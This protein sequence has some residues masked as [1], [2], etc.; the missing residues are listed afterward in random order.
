[1][2]CDTETRDF[3]ALVPASKQPIGEDIRTNARG[4]VKVIAVIATE[5]IGLLVAHGVRVKERM[6]WSLRKNTEEIT[7][8]SDEIGPE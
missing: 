5:T 1:V 7:E 2:D 4:V 6:F 8:S 3:I